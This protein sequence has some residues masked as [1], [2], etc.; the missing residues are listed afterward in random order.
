MKFLNH[1]NLVENELR[2]AK[3]FRTPNGSYQP[4]GGS[5]PAGNIIMDTT[6]DIPKWWDGGAW[7]DFSYG[8][9]GTMNWNIQSDSGSN[10][11]VDQGDILDLTGGTGLVFCLI[12]LKTFNLLGYIDFFK[13]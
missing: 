7:R 3:M 6:D 5:G 11:Q 10:I 8:T 1:L 9:T 13:S 2:Y 12:Y 4:G